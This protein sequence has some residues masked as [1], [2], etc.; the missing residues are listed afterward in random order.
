MNTNKSTMVTKPR[1]IPVRK[2][3]WQ[4]ISDR[5]LR[6]NFKVRCAQIGKSMSAQVE[7]LIREFLKRK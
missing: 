5:Q 6:H 4:L 7:E 1:K 2:T 3:Y